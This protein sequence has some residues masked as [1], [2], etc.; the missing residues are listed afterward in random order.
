MIAAQQSA[1]NVVPPPPADISEPL[2]VTIATTCTKLGV[3]AATVWRL[4]DRNELESV[5]VGRRRLIRYD[6]IK[7]LALKG[8]R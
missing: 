7:A 5:L 3:S 4:L 6:S 1:P 2:L 8:T